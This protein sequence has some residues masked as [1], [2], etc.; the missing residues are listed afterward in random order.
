MVVPNGEQDGKEVA[1]A[2]LGLAVLSSFCRVSQLAADS[3]TIS[4]VPLFVK[5]SWA[6]GHLPNPVRHSNPPWNSCHGH[7]TVSLVLL[8]SKQHRWLPVASQ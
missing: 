1:C 4:L 6:H 8:L 3:V 5:V 2:T 7:D